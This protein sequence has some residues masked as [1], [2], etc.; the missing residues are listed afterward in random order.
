ME[1]SSVKKDGKNFKIEASSG[2]SFSARTLIIA[3]GKKPRMLNVP[4]EREYKNKGVAYC[5]TCDGPLFAG[6]TVAV[7]GGGNSALDA[8]LAM[9]K[10]AKKV[11]LIN[12]HEKFIGDAVMQDKVKAAPNVEILAG[13]KTL[14]IVGEKFVKGIKVETKGKSLDIALEGVFIEIGMIPNSDFIDCVEKNEDKEV[15]IDSASQTSCPG[16]FAA[17]DVTDVPDKQI[18][19]AAGDGAKASLA[20][21]KYLST[22]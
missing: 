21:F 1:V 2:E 8:A 22:H 3:S 11:Y 14:E 6:K 7:I 5:S 10:I 13:T 9:M 20:A 15:L 4:G 12:I 16:I 18:I 19:I 17:G